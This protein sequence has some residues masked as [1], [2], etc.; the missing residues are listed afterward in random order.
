VGDGS[1]AVGRFN[2]PGAMSE[3]VDECNAHGNVFTTLNRPSSGVLATNKMSWQSKGQGLT[4]D[5]FAEI[6]HLPFDFDSVRPKNR[7]ATDEELR[8][9]ID[10]ASAL[11]RDLELAGWPSPVRGCSGNGAHLIYRVSLPNSP[12][13]RNLLDVL[14]KGFEREY[15]TDKVK[16]DPVVRNPA[17]IWRAYGSRN[18][19]G[20]ESSDRPHRPS[21]VIMPPGR[22][23][24]VPAKFIIERAEAYSAVVAEA[25]REAARVLRRV[26][27]GASRYGKGD[28]STLDL[29]GWA[30]TMGLKPVHLKGNV[31]GIQ[32][33]WE[34]EHTTKS[35]VSATA[36]F[37]NP[38]QWPGFKCFHAHCDHRGFVDLMDYV[39]GADAFCAR[40]YE[41]ARLPASSY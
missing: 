3:A 37:D 15:S 23:Q 7:P 8:C 4:D 1:V 25:S 30:A 36:I 33:P 41:I 14:Y 40:Q 32:C 10:A 16:F 12:A 11:S 35:A 20:V 9:A 18:T 39:G 29:L 28:Y 31:Y 27:G 24:E 22:V 5:A 21:Y 38:E 34:H 6:L 17:R 13:A 19:K 26:T 2:D